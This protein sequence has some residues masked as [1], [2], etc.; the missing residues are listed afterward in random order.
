MFAMVGF[1]STANAGADLAHKLVSSLGYLG[2]TAVLPLL[3]LARPLRGLVGA[4]A[5]GLVGYLVIASVGGA[6]PIWVGTT[7]PQPVAPA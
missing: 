3:A 7:L 2:G 6:T 1:Q 5:G 4:A